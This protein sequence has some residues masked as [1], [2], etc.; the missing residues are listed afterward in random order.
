M[1][2][3]KW[4]SPENFQRSA[5]NLIKINARVPMNQ[6][7]KK[8]LTDMGLDTRSSTTFGMLLPRADQEYVFLFVVPPIDLRQKKHRHIK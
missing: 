2:F 1:K 4:A 8:I 5:L 3:L 7:D 6:D